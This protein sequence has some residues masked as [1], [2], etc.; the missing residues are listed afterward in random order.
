MLASI[1]QTATLKRGAAKAEAQYFGGDPQ[2]QPIEGTSMQYAGNTPNDIIVSGNK[3]YMCEQGVWFVSAQPKGP[4]AMADTIPQEIYSIPPQSPKHHVTY[5]TVE[6]STSDSVTYAQTAGYV[7]MC[8]A[9]GAVVW[10]TGYYYPPYWGW[11][12]H[13][14]PVY[15]RPPYY[16]YG[17]GA[18]YNPATGAYARGVRA[19]GPWG[20]YGRG[21]AYNPRT[22]AYARG[23]SAWGPLRFG[24]GSARVQP[25]IRNCRARRRSRRLLQ[26]RL[27]GRL[28]SAKRLPTLGRSRHRRRRRLGLRQVQRQRGGERLSLGRR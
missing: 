25:T 14:Y 22:G 3:Y 21:A 7:G 27:R 18:W 23:G 8:I 4:W 26:R 24:L 15:W 9:F 1:P 2:F 11:G 13:P 5:V 19:Y 17:V 10:G 28:P 6:S 16:S 20:G 12:Y